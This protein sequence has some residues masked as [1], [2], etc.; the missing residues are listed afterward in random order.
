LGA[1][2][3]AELALSS[4]LMT[5]GAKLVTGALAPKI[6]Q[7]SF[8]NLIQDY[9]DFYHMVKENPV[10]TMTDFAKFLGHSFTGAFSSYGAEVLFM[11]PLMM[12]IP[13]SGLFDTVRCSVTL[14]TFAVYPSDS[15]CDLPSPQL[16][17][18]TED[19]KDGAIEA[20]KVIVPGLGFI[21]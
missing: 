16:D 9:V 13:G 11:G 3:G 15:G 1:L 6:F 21:L 4:V 12:A 14:G 20:V 8:D 7:S 10:E 2:L 17:I 5:G 19:L 18:T